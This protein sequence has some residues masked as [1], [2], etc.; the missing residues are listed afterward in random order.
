MGELHEMFIADI[1]QQFTSAKIIGWVI[2]LR[3][4]KFGVV[5]NKLELTQLFEQLDQQYIDNQ[6][7]DSITLE[8]D[9]DD[10]EPI[11]TQVFASP[12][13]NQEEAKEFENFQEEMFSHVLHGLVDEYGTH[14]L[15]DWKQ[16]QAVLLTKERIAIESCVNSINSIWGEPL[17]LLEMLI[18][19]ASDGGAN[20][21]DSN[22]EN[23]VSEEDYVFEALAHLQA[24]GCQVGREILL[25]LKNGFADGAN[26]RWRTLHEI[27][28]TASFIHKHGND[29]AERFLCHSDIETYE[30][31]K[32]HNRDHVAL[33]Y[34]PLSE[35]DMKIHKDRRDV[36]VSRFGEDFENLYGWAATALGKSKPTFAQIEENAGLD[37][38]RSLFKMASTNVHASSKGIEFRLGQPLNKP[39]ILLAGH[40]IYGLGDPAKD[41][42]YYMLLLTSIVLLSKPTVDNMTYINAMQRLREQ[43][44]QAFNQAESELD[45]RDEKIL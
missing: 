34:E 28:V 35:E 15:D 12:I 40:S 44:H 8:F 26:G 1:S 4:K 11:L 37:H 16:K 45:E 27:A 41:T 29:V 7:T 3:L 21:I 9:N 24:W 36:L 23:S 2:A 10:L 22:E 13:P 42:A 18:S 25:L 5:L 19:I 30:A 31:A 20:F 38:F 32:L 17:E 33:G 14:L 43:I 39:K 6:P